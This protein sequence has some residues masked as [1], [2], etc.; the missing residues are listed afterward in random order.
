MVQ[1]LLSEDFANL[2]FFVFLLRSCSH[3]CYTHGADDAEVWPWPPGKPTKQ[4]TA[5][6][7]QTQPLSTA[8]AITTM[9]DD[10][11][12]PAA[13]TAPAAPAAPADPAAPGA[14]S[15]TPA[16]AS[17]VEAPAATAAAAEEEEPNEALK[18]ELPSELKTVHESPAPRDSPIAQ[19]DDTPK[20]RV[21][22]DKLLAQA[23]TFLETGSVRDAP[24]EEKQEFLRAKGLTPAEVEELIRRADGK[25]RR[26]DRR[27]LRE[28]ARIHGV[29][30][31]LL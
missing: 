31:S 29:G 18:S 17:V 14:P 16:P 15:P 7:S 27:R 20:D 22:R 25:K 9:A 21:E 4:L 10:T 1:K 13:P 2:F 23:I 8:T 5:E 28:E 11:K 6:L 30:I 19:D 26:R 3:K 24:L 12:A